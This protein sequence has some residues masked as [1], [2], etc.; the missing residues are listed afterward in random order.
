MLSVLTLGLAGA[1]AYAPSLSRVARGGSPLRAPPL[2]MAADPTKVYQRAEFWNK[3]QASFRSRAVSTSG[4]TPLPPTPPHPTPH[5]VCWT[6]LST[7]VHAPCSGAPPPPLP[8]TPSH[9]PPPHPHPNP[10][11]VVWTSLSTCLALSMPRRTPPPLPRVYIA[12]RC[13]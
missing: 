6:S 1:V 10:H 12:Y 2:S 4:S 13:L 11:P 5:P 3:E 8:P 7:R 9:P